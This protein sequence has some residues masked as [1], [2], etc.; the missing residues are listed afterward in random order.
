MVHLLLNMYISD[1]KKK[2]L[3]DTI[4]LLMIPVLLSHSLYIYIYIYIYIALNQKFNSNLHHI[5]KWFQTSQLV[6]N[7]NQTYILKLTASKSPIY[8]LNIIHVDHSCH[9]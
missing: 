4:L 5:S 8:P 2:K 1:L 9:C 3:S 7:A 6:L